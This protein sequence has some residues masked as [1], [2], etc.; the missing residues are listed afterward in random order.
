[1]LPIVRWLM[2]LLFISQP[3]VASEKIYTFAV[4]PQQSIAEL[5]EEWLPFVNWLSTKTGIKLRFVTAPDIPTFEHKLNQGEY[6]IAYMN[7]YHY[8]TFHEEPG[9]Q[10]IAKEKDHLLRGLIVVRKDSDIS[11][12]KDLNQKTVVFPAPNAFAASILTRAALNDAGVHAN[13]KFVTSHSSVYL[14][15]A[16]GKYPAGGG[17]GRTFYMLD[18]AIRDQLRIL[19]VT[20]TYTPH[21]IAV[22]ASV[23]SSVTA[24]LQQAMIDMSNDPNGKQLLKAIGFDSGIESANDSDW[25]DIRALHIQPQDNS[26]EARD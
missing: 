14:N 6:D 18:D 11:D 20:P 19:W 13:S 26:H 16:Q 5:A 1:M 12:I 7:P 9:Y 8:I 2:M 24:R 21:T 10:A 4:V 23:P 3:T 17:I 22:S 25:N 15:V